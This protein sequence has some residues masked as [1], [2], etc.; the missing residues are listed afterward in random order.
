MTGKTKILHLWFTPWSCMEK[1]LAVFWL[2]FR[3]TQYTFYRHTLQEQPCSQC[4]HC[5]I[6]HCPVSQHCLEL[7]F[8]LAQDAF[9]EDI[10]AG[11]GRGLSTPNNFSPQRSVQNS[12]MGQTAH[13]RVPRKISEEN[14]ETLLLFGWGFFLCFVFGGFFNKI[15]EKTSPRTIP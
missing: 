1:C 10:I 4:R 8:T 11:R 12:I 3:S 15:W 5:I 2:I 6:F 9:Q 7:I 14:T 13:A